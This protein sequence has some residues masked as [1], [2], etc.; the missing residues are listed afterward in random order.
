MSILRESDGLMSA[1]GED[2]TGTVRA[3]G[4]SDIRR[5]DGAE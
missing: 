5:G 2:V 4:V 1:P 3:V